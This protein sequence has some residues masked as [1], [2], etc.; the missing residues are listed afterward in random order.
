MIV[1]LAVAG[2]AYALANAHAAGLFRRPTYT[3][4]APEGSLMATYEDLKTPALADAAAVPA[5]DAA[6]A[7]AKAVD[8]AAIAQSATS[9]GA[10]AAAI[11]TAGGSLL[12]PTV[13][14]PVEYRSSDGVTFQTVVLPLITDTVPVPASAPTPVVTPVVTP[15]A[16][17]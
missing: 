1:A 13:T 3:A 4:I 12:D 9:T 7:A 14:P 10:F 2:T 15:P 16:A 11:K 5:A 8:V 17:S 6:L